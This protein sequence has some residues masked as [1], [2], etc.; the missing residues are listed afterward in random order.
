ML[1][2]RNSATSPYVRKV[3]V[4]LLETGLEDRVELIDTQVTPT[5]PNAELNVDNPIGKVPVLLTENGMALYDSP[6]ICEYLDS[7]HSGTKMFPVN[8]VSR[9]LALRRQ[10]LGDGLL[11]AAILGR[12]ESTLRPA[13]KL[14]QDWLDAQIG[15]I[16][17]SLGAM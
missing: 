1:K 9:W 11:D 15:K 10:A 4:L 13:A 5:N 7:L 12:Y 3:R 16:D 17:R 2:L 6:V 14:W 8:G